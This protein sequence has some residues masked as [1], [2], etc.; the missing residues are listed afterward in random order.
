VVP[1]IEVARFRT[2][3]GHPYVV[4]HNPTVHTYLKLDPRELGI[5]GLMDGTRT[6]KSLVVA[7]YQR[8][9]V[10]ALSR[11]AGLVEI[12]RAHRF[13]TEPPSDPYGQLERALTRRHPVALVTHFIHRFLEPQV[14]IGTIDRRLSDWFHSW[15]RWFFSRP[16]AIIGTAIGLAAPVFFLLELARPRYTLFTTGGS[17]LS[18]LLILT[19]LQALTVGI[20]EIGHGLA[21]KYAGRSVPKAGMMLYFGLPVA[22]VDTTDVWMAPL[23][24]RVL[25]SLAGPWTG[26]V[27]AGLC[28]TVS[29]LLPAGPVGSFLFA[30]GFVLLFNTLLNFNPLLEMDGYYLLVDLAEKPMLRSRAFSFIRRP[31]WH[32]LRRRDHLTRE[33][34]LFALFGLAAVA[35]SGFA[36]FLG[37]RLWRLRLAGLVKD[38]W[39]RGAGGKALVIV[40]TV[41][42][43]GLVALAVWGIATRVARW[44]SKRM[45]ALSGRA[46]EFRRREALRALRGVPLWSEVATGRLLEIAEAMRV[47]DV[48]PGEVVVRQGEQGDRFYVIVQGSFE[49]LVDGEF[50]RRLGPGDYFGERA[51]LQDAPRAATV[52]GTEPGR[53]LWLD[54][55][56]FRSTLAHD[57]ATLSRLEA[58]LDD[59]QRLADIP[60]F[61]DLSPTEL[62]LLLARMER[63]SAQGSATILQQGQ[64]GERFYVVRSG[65]VD[66]ER[67]GRHVATLQEGD[68][69][70]EISLLLSVPVT[71]TARAAP[72]AEL[73]ALDGEDFRDLLVRYC[74]RAV[75]LEQMTH[76]RLEDL[77]RLEL[78][79]QD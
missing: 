27:L 7:Y 58:A 14:S 25:T 17:Y 21:V 11:I 12:L 61:R 42:L 59:R 34:R 49:V 36:L 53:V 5:L 37:I 23:G 19:G 57:L 70:G 47:E 6:V 9:G 40:A 67:E 20:H 69:F 77:K 28:T 72:A 35:Y 18:G 56:T 31:L 78:I 45:A 26:L 41:L 63:V 68:A 79:D 32:K 60:M 50:D 38:A 71:A 13:L 66:I 73:L 22:Y 8:H 44:I 10:L 39:S 52:I 74:N 3:S 2:R 1:G 75:D 15:G 4:I 64:E 43:G 54:R 29:Y 76:V 24:K 62:D 33:E 51:L 46:R 48:S 30:W 16:V 65:A 55:E